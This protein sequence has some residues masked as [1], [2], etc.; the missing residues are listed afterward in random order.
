MS[1][2]LISFVNVKL[3]FTPEGGSA[4]STSCIFEIS[5]LGSTREVNKKKCL[6]DKTLIAVGAKEWE[7]LNFKVPYGET[8]DEFHDVVSTAYDNNKRGSLEIEFDNM[9]DA[10]TS[11]TKITGNSFITSYKPDNE[12]KSIVS[13]FTADWDGEPVTTKAQ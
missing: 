8:A 6:N 2:S 5:G 10:G 1:D 13:T 12:D 11:G 9:P 4:V 7:T 3:T